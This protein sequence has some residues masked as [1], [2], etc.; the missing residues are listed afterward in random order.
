M[1]NT[2]STGTRVDPEARQLLCEAY[3]S[4]SSSLPKRTTLQLVTV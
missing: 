1:G 3:D 2:G 4:S